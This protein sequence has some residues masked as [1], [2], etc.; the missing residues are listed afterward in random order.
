MISEIYKIMI[1]YNIS[2]FKFNLKIQGKIIKYELPPLIETRE[3]IIYLFGT[4]ALLTGQYSKN[5]IYQIIKLPV[6]KI[7]EE[8]F[9]DFTFVK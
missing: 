2:V 9:T 5:V 4:L 7:R 3:I 8:L 1:T 6:K